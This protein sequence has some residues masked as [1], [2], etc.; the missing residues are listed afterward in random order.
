MAQEN[1]DLTLTAAETAPDA[2]GGLDRLARGL[3]GLTSLMAVIGIG[4][5][6]VVGVTMSVDVVILRTI[7]VVSIPGSNEIYAALMCTAIALVMPNGL[8]A[9]AILEMDLLVNTFSPRV[10][11]WLRCL[12]ATI[13]AGCLV[14]L[15]WAI[16]GQVEMAWQTGSQSL[17]FQIP[18]WYSYA[19]ILFAL[20]VSLPVS[21]VNVALQ[22]REIPG[23]PV[24][25]GLSAL[26]AGVAVL[27]VGYWLAATYQTYF[28]SNMM[29]SALWL[30]LALWVM[31][32]LFVPVAAALTF[33]AL[34]GVMGFFGSGAAVSVLGS[35]TVG[36]LTSA[37][38]AIIP[39][40]LMMGSFA[41]TSG[42]A[43]DIYRLAN[44][45]F[46]PFRGGL[47]LATVA[48]CAGFGALTGSSIATVATIGSAAFPEMKKRGYSPALSAGTITAGGTLGQLTPPSTAIV[49]YALLVE[50][51][52]GSL[53]MALL[54]P[55]A[56]TLALYMVAIVLSVRLGAAGPAG[57]PWNPREIGAA[58]VRCI[59]AFILF[60]L[61]IGG[62]FFGVFTATEAA[63]L[64]AILAVAV[65]LLRGR[66]T[67]QNFLQVA[68][69]TT[70]ST[71]MIYF[72]IIGALTLTFLMSSTGVAQELSRMLLDT[73][74]EPWMIVSLIAILFILLGT[75]MDS[76][77]IMMIT[78]STT[79]ALMQGLGYDLIWWGVMMVVVVEIGVITPPFGINLFMMRS[80]APE[81]SLTEM[82]RGVIPF[83]VADLLKVALLIALP[84]LPLL[85]LS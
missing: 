45:L 16:W 19:L 37:D 11:A 83:V 38:L 53:Y 35:E 58:A 63:S 41:V 7:F 62:I 61:V 48:G 5:F 2:A 17:L 25:G 10:V 14:A 27:A 47:A 79:G 65:T 69:D 73:Q 72:L 85:L 6:L 55:A 71:S 43:S 54:I 23:A 74:L 34:V 49:V 33:C 30:V 52:I 77:T 84:G 59:P 57:E 12:G 51:S 22:A 36:L 3:A 75:I 18:Y 4:L 40:F 29:M 50:E 80:V 78:A 13:F 20:V 68:S 81:L 32:L 76:M 8:A 56:V 60:G 21:L 28:L 70:K 9:R 44:A 26:V 39:F 24:A 1:A 66:L 64:G 15:A 46:S 42:M 31:I 82:Y 67:R